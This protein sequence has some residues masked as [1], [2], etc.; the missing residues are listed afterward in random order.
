MPSTWHR[1]CLADG[2]P[3]SAL[4]ALASFRTMDDFRPAVQASLTALGADTLDLLRRSD[5]LHTLVRRHLIEEATT[6]LIPPEELI[7]KALVNHC[8]QE[9]LN[10]EAALTTWLEER[11][12]SREELLHQVSLPLKLSKLALDSYSIQ[13]EARFLQRKEAI[14]QVTYSLLR[15]KDSGMAHELY[16]QLEAGEASFESLASDHSEGPE[17]RSSGKVGPG[18]LMRAHPQLR[19]RL[20]TATPGVVLEPILIENW[21][22]VT[23]LEERH[24]ASFDAPM[25]QRMASELLQDWLRI[26]TKEVVKSLCTGKN[27]RAEP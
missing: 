8:R 10:G 13:A 26:E 4:N 5:L 6:S 21:W 7:K 3:C 27:D 22:V 20:R 23:R 2:N 24:E 15:V 11:C 1:F 19:Q 14:D 18:S 17:K 25:R 9:N 12:M 16:L